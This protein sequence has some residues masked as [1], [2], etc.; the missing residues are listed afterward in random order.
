MVCGAFLD[1][2]IGGLPI[3]LIALIGGVHFAVGLM[4]LLVGVDGF[5][6]LAPWPWARLW[7]RRSFCGSHSLEALGA[8]CLSWIVL[9]K[10]S[11]QANRAHGSRSFPGSR[12]ST[13]ALPQCSYW[14]SRRMS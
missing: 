7:F 8:F 4:T 10:T 14:L 1:V 11:S 13:K 3:L 5:A 2:D 6:G 12:A 9:S